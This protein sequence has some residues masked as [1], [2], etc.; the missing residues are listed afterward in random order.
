MR[1]NIEYVNHV[2][3]RLSLLCCKEARLFRIFY[4]ISFPLADVHQRHEAFC[5]LFWIWHVGIQGHREDAQGLLVTVFASPQPASP[6]HSPT[7]RLIPPP[8]TVVLL[9]AIWAYTP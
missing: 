9:T 3:G 5:C 4:A 8:L 6:T 7:D 2:H 1:C